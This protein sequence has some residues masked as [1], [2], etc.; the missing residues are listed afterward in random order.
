MA[1]IA[2]ANQKGGV[3]KT[4]T[5]AAVASILSQEGYRVLLVD[6]D[7]QRN[8]DMVAGHLGMPLE[9]SRNDH[10]TLS[11]LQVLRKECTVEDAVVPSAIG[12]LLRASSQLYGW[13]GNRCLAEPVYMKLLR[14]WTSLEQLLGTLKEGTCDLP[15]PLALRQCYH[16]VN[17]MGTLLQPTPQQ[18]IPQVL[19]EKTEDYRIL[20]EALSPV[21]HKYDYILI[22]TN[23]TLTLLTLNAL[24][25]CSHLVI[26][27]FPES[28]AIE[29]TLELHET[30]ET[31][32]KLEPE[33]DLQL[34][35]VLLTKYA[36]RR[37]KSRRHIEILSH[38]VET[39]LG[40]YFFQTKIRESERASEYV[41]ARMD[42][43]RHDPT[44]QT[45]MDYRDFVKE[46]KQRIAYDLATDRRLY[47]KQV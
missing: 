46:L 31:I 12:D 5:V 41:E 36:P 32:K 47:A 2:F 25:A 33:R 39:M 44:G 11:I 1:V 24:Y 40:E 19:A 6:L 23:P 42:I 29:A 35:G 45:A 21:L 9:I 28:S 37:L 30:V 3:G 4:M 22:D 15:M 10:E 34:A 43:I 26:P 18:S 14:E 13:Q 7:A 38:V 17:H 27:V 20:E 16:K 8:L